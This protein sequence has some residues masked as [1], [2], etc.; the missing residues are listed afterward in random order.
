MRRL[1]PI[2]QDQK[3]SPLFQFLPSFQT[4]T[5][6]DFSTVGS[7]FEESSSSSSFLL[8]HSPGLDS[9]LG[10]PGIRMGSVIEVAGEAGAGK[11]QMCLQLCCTVQVTRVRNM[12]KLNMISVDFLYPIKLPPRKPSNGEP[13]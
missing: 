9:V 10:G 2:F 5:L 13:T 6:S 1:T 3:T 11:S 8:T 4:L 12:R 7:I